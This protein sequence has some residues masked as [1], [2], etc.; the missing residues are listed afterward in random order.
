MQTPWGDIEVADAHVHFLSWNFYSTLA[1]QK[2]EGTVVETML[3]SLAIPIPPRDPA[4]FGR[5][6]AAELDRRGVSRACLIASVP[7]DEDS[8]AAALAACPGR[9]H[10]YFFLNPCQTDALN[11]LERAFAAGLRGVCLFPAMFGFSMGSPEVAAIAER[12]AIQPGAI[13]FVHCGVLSVGI[14]RRLGVGSLFDMRYSNPLTLH[15]LALRY[16]ALP[17]VLPHF[18]AGLFREALML[19]DLCPN[20]YLDT[21]SSNSW[22]KYLC[23][24]PTLEQVFERALDVAGPRRLLF[25]TDSSVFPRG[26]NNEIFDLQVETML[27]LNVSANDAKSILAGNLNRISSPA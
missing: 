20:V 5:Q 10:G 26:W 13:L 19:A 8:V 27:K 16:P 12:A 4:E 23:P 2:G 24:P 15:H 7:G 6:W 18:G 25:G 22:T 3:E 1:R 9:F 14:R 11:R 21:S 17:F